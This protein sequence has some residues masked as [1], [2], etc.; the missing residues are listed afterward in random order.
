LFEKR[1]S[2][3]RQHVLFGEGETTINE[4]VPFAQRY[5]KSKDTRIKTWQITFPG[6]PLPG[7]PVRMPVEVRKNW[8]DCGRQEYLVEDVVTGKKIKQIYDPTQRR[9]QVIQDAEDIMTGRGCEVPGAA[10][11]RC[12]TWVGPSGGTRLIKALK[13]PV[14][15]TPQDLLGRIAYALSIQELD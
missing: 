4:M 8:G 15:E 12:I 1:V 11:D 13:I 9:T 10:F 6:A 14:Q 2:L 7:K 5:V 3:K